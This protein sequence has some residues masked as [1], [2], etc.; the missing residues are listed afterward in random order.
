MTCSQLPE[1]IEKGNNDDVSIFSV[2]SE[3]VLKSKDGSVVILGM[4]S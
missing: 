4:L 2:T 1:L 3:K